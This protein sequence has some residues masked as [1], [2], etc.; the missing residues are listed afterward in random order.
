MSNYPEEPGAK[1]VEATITPSNT[2]EGRYQAS[3]TATFEGGTTS[4]DVL[5]WYDDE[6]TF[7]KEEFVGLTRKEVIDLFMKKDGEYLRS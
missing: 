5:A 1:I 3:L 2:K 6:L 4:T 7:R